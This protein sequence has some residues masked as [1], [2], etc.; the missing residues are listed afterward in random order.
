ML[1]YS[2]PL[3]L[4]GAASPRSPRQDRA[5]GFPSFLAIGLP[6]VWMST[7]PS[8]FFFEGGDLTFRV[9]GVDYM[10]F[11]KNFPFLKRLRVWLTG[12]RSVS[13]FV[14]SCLTFAYA[15]GI[16]W[17]SFR[18]QATCL[19]QSSGGFAHVSTSFFAK[20]SNSF[21]LFL[22][23]YGV[24]LKNSQIPKGYCETGYIWAKNDFR[25]M[26][27]EFG[28]YSREREFFNIF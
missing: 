9:S 2:S 4:S 26:V 20:T 3:S 19:C 16:V 6:M 14:F 13:F 27:W 12:I 21:T 11:L 18:T 28:N 15:R 25:E 17:Y 24:F 5:D 23:F 10:A 7:I 1:L 8:A 22:V